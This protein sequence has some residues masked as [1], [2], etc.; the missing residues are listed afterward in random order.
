MKS[1]VFTLLSCFSLAACAQPANPQ[2]ANGQKINV[3]GASAAAA[4]P[5]AEPSFATGT[6][7]A[8]VRDVLKQLNPDVRVDSIESAPIPGFRQV[9]AGGQVIYVS[10]DGKYLMQGSLLDIANKKDVSESA[11]AKV[12]E[13]VL[14]TLPMADRIV[15]SPTGAPRYK[16][17]VLTDIECGYCRKFHSEIAEYNKRGI[18]VEYMAFPRAGLGSADYRKMVSVWCADDR[19]K[20]LTDAKNDRPVTA[21]TC[22]TPVDMQYNAGLRM[23]L[24]G[25][26]MILTTDG[27]MVGGYLPPDALLQRMQQMETES[28]AAA[29]A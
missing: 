24:T 2:A 29:G 21:K 19:K 5:I 9:V 14:K 8:R 7:E 12:R 25:T 16:V 6:P 22:T 11:L 18:E 20:A 1:L 27:Q 26:P 13:K 10:D 4:K 17:V 3:G 15:F 23:G 28:K